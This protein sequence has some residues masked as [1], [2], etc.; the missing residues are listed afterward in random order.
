MLSKKITL[1]MYVRWS[2]LNTIRTLNPPFSCRIS[3]I[4]LTLYLK[5]LFSLAKT[6]FA[7]KMFS[8][9]SRA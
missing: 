2:N 7:D 6:V 5:S 1:K 8:K 3:Y 4:Q 9:Y